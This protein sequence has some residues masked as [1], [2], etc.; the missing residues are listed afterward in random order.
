MGHTQLDCV[1]QHTKWEKTRGTK[2]SSNNIHQQQTFEYTIRLIVFESIPTKRF[3]CIDFNYTI[4]YKYMQHTQQCIVIFNVYL[5]VFIHASKSLL[6]C[7]YDPALC[8]LSVGCPANVQFCFVCFF[9]INY[10][11]RWKNRHKL[12]WK[13]ATRSSK[14][15]SYRFLLYIA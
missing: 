5:F 6:V 13:K 8:V 10:D 12:F 7:Y 4:I 11:C 15:L 2:A 9:F 1:T 14:L 3:D